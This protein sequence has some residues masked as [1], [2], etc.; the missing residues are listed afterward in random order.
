MIA[1][2]GLFAKNLDAVVNS[3]EHGADALAF[4][5]S[6]DLCGRRRWTGIQRRRLG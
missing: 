4:G 2:P 3:C 1:A 5:P 6:T